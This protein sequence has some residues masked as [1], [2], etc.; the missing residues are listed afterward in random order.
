VKIPWFSNGETLARMLVMQC[1]LFIGFG[2]GS[3]LGGARIGPFIGLIVGAWITS[4]MKLGKPTNLS[5]FRH[6]EM[7]V[8]VAAFVT[9]LWAGDWVGTKFGHD[10][11]GIGIAG[12]IAITIVDRTEKYVDNRYLSPRLDQTIHPVQ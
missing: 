9:F 5:V 12:L 6:W 2:A 11:V 4:H 7:W 10:L 1:C 8:G 3:A